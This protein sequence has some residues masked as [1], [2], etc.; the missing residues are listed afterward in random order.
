MK[1]SSRGPRLAYGLPV[2]GL[3][4]LSWKLRNSSNS[5]STR[6][7]I[8]LVDP[9]ALDDVDDQPRAGQSEGGEQ[10]DR[11]GDADAHRDARPLGP[12]ARVC[13]CSVVAATGT[14]GVVVTAARAGTAPGAAGAIGPAA[15]SARA[16]AGV[17]VGVVTP[18]GPGVAVA[19]VVVPVVRVW[20]ASGMSSSPWPLPWPELSSPSSLPGPS[21]RRRPDR[22]P[23]RRRDRR[24]DRRW[25]RCWGCRWRRC[26]DPRSRRPR[27]SRWARSD[28]DG[29]PDCS[30]MI[31]VSR[32]A[33][34]SAADATRVPATNA[35]SGSTRARAAKTFQK[36]RMTPMIIHQGG[37]AVRAP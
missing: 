29:V 5:W 37:P 32:G 18:A 6:S 10:G 36:L 33:G 22:H 19:A 2:S 27:G 11:R 20:V 24:R 31:I 14:A 7:A 15:G 26:W 34:S 35:P 28:W 23:D 9:L 17:V 8:S 1:A 13:S 3:T 4:S 12:G 30:S 25:R 16:V 21:C